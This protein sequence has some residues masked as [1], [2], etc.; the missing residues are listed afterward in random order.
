CPFA[1]HGQTAATTRVPQ[2]QRRTGQAHDNRRS[3]GRQPRGVWRQLEV[4]WSLPAVSPPLVRGEYLGAA[5][6]RLRRVSVCFPESR[7]GGG[8]VPT[9]PD[10]YDVAKSAAG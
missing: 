9:G 4:Y 5:R 8:S 3:H 10:Y 6:K 7:A 1:P 2:R